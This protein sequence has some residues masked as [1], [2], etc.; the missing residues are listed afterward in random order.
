MKIDVDK[1][2]PSTVT[3]EELLTIIRELKTK[4]ADLERRLGLNSSNSGK[5]PSTDGLNK[6]SPKS[7]RSPTG[8]GFGGQKG[9]K[10]NTLNQVDV[11]DETITSTVSECS[12]CH[13]SLDAIDVTS[14]EERQEF[15]VVIKRHVRA[16]VRDV[17]ICHCGHINRGTFRNIL[18]VMSSMVRRQR[19][20]ISRS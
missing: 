20:S 15:D 10:G 2:D 4:V 19:R 8:K 16:Y 18:K 1:L 5:T 12:H 11:A 13:F 3:T 14:V 6:P 7:Q 9:H 17:K